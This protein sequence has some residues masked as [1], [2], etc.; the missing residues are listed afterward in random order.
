MCRLT[1]RNPDDG[2]IYLYA[3]SANVVGKLADYEDIGTV[4]EFRELKEKATA[5]KALVARYGWD[6]PCCGTFHSINGKYCSKCGQAVEL[7]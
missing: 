5:V 7:D 6:C 1:W 2:K 3:Q 4:S